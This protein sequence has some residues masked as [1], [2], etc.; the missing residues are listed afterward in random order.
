LLFSKAGGIDATCIDACRYQCVLYSA[1]PFVGQGEVVFGGAAF[2][3]MTLDQYAERSSLCERLSIRGDSLL[4]V[5]TNGGG[6]VIEIYVFD[7]LREPLFIGL[8]DRLFNHR[9]R[10]GHG[11][12]DAF[13][14]VLLPARS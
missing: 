5:R 14:G 10:C 2:I 6:I 12:S 1:G 8:R 7:V 9:W 11:Y 3:R 13:G 4:G